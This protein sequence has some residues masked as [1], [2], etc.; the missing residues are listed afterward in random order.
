MLANEPVLFLLLGC[1]T[2]LATHFHQLASPGVGSLPQ[3]GCY[4]VTA[5]QHKEGLV[6]DYRVKVVCG[7]EGERDNRDM[8]AFRMINNWYHDEEI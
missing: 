4:H 5:T 6:F 2:L 1:R 3:A 7:G 8:R